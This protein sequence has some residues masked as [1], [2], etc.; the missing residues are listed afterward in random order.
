MAGCARVRTQ[1]Y[2]TPALLTQQEQ[3]NVL[4][5]LNPI[6]FQVLLDL[7]APSQGRPLLRR[8]SAPHPAYTLWAKRRAGLISLLHHEKPATAAPQSLLNTTHT[9]FHNCRLTLFALLYLSALEYVSVQFWLCL[10]Q[11]FTDRR[12][13]C[14]ASAP[15]AH[16]LDAGRRDAAQASPPTL[17]MVARDT[18]D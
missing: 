5:G 13:S 3:L 1:S 2:R 10:K 7:F 8:R 12:S 16:S 4:G 9:H 6:F 11:E 18:G 14:Y 15:N 17:R